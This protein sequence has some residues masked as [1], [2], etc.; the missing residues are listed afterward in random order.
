MR[1]RSGPLIGFGADH[2]NLWQ[3]ALEPLLIVSL[4]CAPLA[5][6]AARDRAPACL[7]RARQPPD[8]PRPDP[9]LPCPMQPVSITPPTLPSDLTDTREFQLFPQPTQPRPPA[10]SA[11][12]GATSRMRVKKRDGRLEPV[13][14]QKI[15]RA[16]E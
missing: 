12:A 16:V 5:G 2:N 3:S 14:V 10:P 1:P 8:P 6:K 15:V 7:R 13:D 9:P 11:A 4:S